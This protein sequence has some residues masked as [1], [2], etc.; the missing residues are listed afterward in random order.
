MSNPISNQTICLVVTTQEAARHM[1]QI[2]EHLCRQY[3]PVQLFAT[4]NAGKVFDE[5]GLG[6]TP[7][8]AVKNGFEPL[9]TKV[10]ASAALVIT[11]ISKF[12][13]GVLQQLPKSIQRVVYYV[14]PKKIE[15]LSPAN[16]ELV[17]KMM[18]LSDHYLFANANFAH[19][20]NDAKIK[21][22]GNGP[23]LDRVEMLKSEKIDL[24]KKDKTRADLFTKYKIPEKK[25]KVV[26]IYGGEGEEYYK[27]TF[28]KLIEALE[29]LDPKGES[30]TY[31]FTQHPGIKKINL[32]PQFTLL[33]E[34]DEVSLLS[35]AQRVIY[36]GHR[37]LL[38]LKADLPHI[39]V[40]PETTPEELSKGL[41]SLEK[42]TAETVE[43][44]FRGAGYRMDWQKRL[45]FLIPQSTL[46]QAKRAKRE[47]S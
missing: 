21:G 46:P 16:S 33:Q 15:E 28:P 1:G 45:A 32:G 3:A 4:R 41:E 47:P 13:R 43:K 37:S 26:L 31:L 36:H 24:R 25:Q 27:G 7:F 38:S 2:T 34:E 17:M 42:P 20:Y 9:M 14:S 18:G 30:Y 10:A 39:A 40:T 29:C 19:G 11:D 44:R 23:L 35:I 8:R 12:S 6:Y 22:I 5:M